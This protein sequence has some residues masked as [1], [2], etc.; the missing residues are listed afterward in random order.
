MQTLTDCERTIR[1]NVRNFLM[2]ATVDELRRELRI[3]EE[4]GD[5]LRARFVR[6]LI[7]ESEYKHPTL[8]S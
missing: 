7:D 2:V 6:E 3:S 5:A 1:Q 4:R 8:E